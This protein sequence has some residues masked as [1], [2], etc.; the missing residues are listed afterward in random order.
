MNMI[1]KAE[2]NV[3]KRAISIN[4]T[5]SSAVVVNPFEFSPV[6]ENP[7]YPFFP[8]FFFFIKYFRSEIKVFIYSVGRERKKKGKSREG[9]M[10]GSRMS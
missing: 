6:A 2:N 8:L 4:Q 1:I 7:L 10:G 9:K 5:A 3:I